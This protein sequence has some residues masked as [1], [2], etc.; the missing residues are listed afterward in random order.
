MLKNR[1]DEVEREYTEF[2]DEV[3]RLEGTYVDNLK[4]VNKA[5]KKMEDSYHSKKGE[6][7]S[8]LER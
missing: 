8:S 2:L 3:K 1:G 5:R 6:C 4:D 7:K